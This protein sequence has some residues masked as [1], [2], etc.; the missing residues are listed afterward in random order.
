MVQAGWSSNAWIV[1]AMLAGGDALAAP[2]QWGVGPRLG[3]SL[4]PVRQPALWPGRV[5]Q[6]GEIHR[7]PWNL[8]FGVASAFYVTP[9]S[10]INGLL[11]V[12][13]GQ[14]FSDGALIATY[15]YVVD[16]GAVD[17]AFGGGLGFG[18]STWLGEREA[19]L[20]VGHLP[21]R[22]E[23]QGLYKDRERGWQFTLFGE[24]RM[25]VVSGFRDAGGSRREAGWGLYLTAGLEFSLLFGDMRPQRPTGRASER[26]RRS[27]TDDAL[28]GWQSP[29]PDLDTLGEHDDE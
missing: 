7:V 8:R 16:L 9:R 5:E 22:A 26:A 24:W 1:L 25:P 14:R 27:A 29:P 19:R 3:S 18:G 4:F 21:I 20:R 12:D 23:V 11:S 10:R 13:A 6:S 28:D 15:N 17:L 2:Y